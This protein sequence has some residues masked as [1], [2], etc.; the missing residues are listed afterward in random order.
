MLRLSCAVVLQLLGVAELR[1]R[2]FDGHLPGNGFPYD[3]L[4]RAGYLVPGG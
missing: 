3:L 2:E 4:A 1:Y